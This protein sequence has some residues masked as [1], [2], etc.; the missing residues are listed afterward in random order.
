M[1]D[2]RHIKA[3]RVLGKGSYGTVY[4]YHNEE[5][6][7]KYAIKIN[8]KNEETQD[9]NPDTI[10]DINALKI[11][12]HPN[13]VELHDV[14]ISE[15]HVKMLFELADYDL[16]HAVFNNKIDLDTVPELIYPIFEAVAYCH[17]KNVLHLD[18]KP[19]NI[20]VFKDGDKET[21]KLCDFGISNLGY[22]TIHPG[23]MNTNV[24]SS[25]FRS[26]NLFLEDSN[27][28]S[29]V[30]IWSLGCLLYTIYTKYL[31]FDAKDTPSVLRRIVKVL[32]V[33][34]TDVWSN[35]VD[36]PKWNSIKN[37]KSKP[38]G[39]NDSAITSR[40]ELLDLIN[41]IFN[42]SNFNEPR[43]ADH[44]SKILSHPYFK[45]VNKIST[46]KRFCC[47]ESIKENDYIIPLSSNKTY[48]TCRS[49]LFEYGLSIAYIM[50]MSLRSL[51]LA[52]SIVDRYSDIR[53]SKDRLVQKDELNC[54]LMV[55]MMLTMKIDGSGKVPYYDA[56][57]DF[58]NG[59][60]TKNTF[61]AM[62]E[63]MIVTLDWKIHTY[64]SYD[65][66][67]VILRD[68]DVINNINIRDTASIILL[69]LYIYGNIHGRDNYDIANIVIDMTLFLNQT[70]SISETEYD[71]F[72]ILRK[73][74]VPEKYRQKIN[75]YV[76]YEFYYD[77]FSNDIELLYK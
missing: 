19:Q 22:R 65:F 2:N 39:I 57:E 34:T 52:F 12:N 29:M 44:M 31:L 60:I 38:I 49:I 3:D 72:S 67:N 37:I 50:S 14:T 77:S 28:G 74:N 59:A 10:T 69:I 36:L 9:I 18:I 64:T 70:R 35:V 32:G 68:I 7:K 42:Y 48:I 6:E 75:M 16:F 30:D 23:L 15:K 71:R 24:C 66:M 20:L 54:I 5:D 63:D 11:L 21:W 53:S 26:I 62:E 1:I 61:I 58:C 25:A 40:P 27:Y 76:G 45:D 73:I 13:I 17:N 55:A 4:L 8:N 51:F 46:F 41:T 43:D 33:P 47:L 56:F